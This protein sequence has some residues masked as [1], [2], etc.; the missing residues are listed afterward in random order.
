[1]VLSLKFLVPTAA[2]LLLCARLM[3]IVG[4]NNVVDGGYPITDDQIGNN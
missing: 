4:A 2:S 3:P 1:M